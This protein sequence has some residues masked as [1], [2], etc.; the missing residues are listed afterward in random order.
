MSDP[1]DPY[2][3]LPG[4]TDPYADL[5]D[6]SGD[7][8]LPPMEPPAT[9]PAQPPGSPLLTGLIIG[10]LLIALSVA[11]FQ[12]LGSDDSG[13]AAP[14]DTSTTTGDGDT[15]TTTGDGQTTT[16]DAGATTTSPG[17]D[18]YPPVGDPIPVEDLKMK[19]DGFK[20]EVDGVSDIVFGTGADSAIGQL[21]ASFGA[22]TQDTGWQVSTEQFGVC[23]G[24]FERIVYFGPFAAIVTKPDGQEIF[25]G[26]RSDLQFGDLTNP[27][28]SLETLS[29][30]KIGDTVGKLKEVYSG[31][32]VE[33]STDTKLGQIYQVIG[34]STGNLLLWG[35][36]DGTADTDRVIGIYAPDVCDRS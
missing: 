15:S 26:Y 4:W 24:D 7:T 2:E 10:L 33:F 35:P 22:S 12:V 5:T 36:V 19:A 32:K 29:G 25:N 30:L 23:N 20:V 34:G 31:E 17:T 11:V 28:A 13:T 6:I 18:P 8:P 3:N 21:V 1:Q 14:S 27:A 9:P 16:T